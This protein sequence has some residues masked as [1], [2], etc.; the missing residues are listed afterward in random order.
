MEDVRY[1]EKLAKEA[2]IWGSIAAQ[3]A[4]TLLPDWQYHRALR[5]NAIMH[6][7][8]IAAML[9]DVQPGSRVLE[10][11]CGSG[12]LTIG[13][14]QRGARVHGL[15]IGAKAIEVARSYYESVKD[16]LS[17]TATYQVA[18]L[19]STDLPIDYYDMVVAKGVLHHLLNLESLIDRVHGALRPGGLLWVS[20]TN[21]DE[22]MPVVLIASV[23]TFVLP[24]Q[25]SYHDKIHG[26]FRFGIRAPE[27][28]KLSMQGS[29]LSPFEGIGRQVDW[30]ALISKRFII[31]RRIDHPA[32]TGYVTAEIKLSDRLALPLL[33]MMY[34]LDRA[35]V[36][37]KIVR[38]TG[39]TL[40]ARK[41][42]LPQQAP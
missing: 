8:H 4:I 12:W 27:R 31:E 1:A 2:E 10:L 37:T 21:G 14:A 15:D 34:Q 3:Q 28:I 13:M 39:L 9:N 22:A 18:D 20:D 25:V 17:G 29:G 38:S 41:A 23:L 33:H 16:K 26:L 7:P 24:T 42:P 6:T 30:L 19:N 35:L 5:H 11:G 36:R 40:Y 32:F